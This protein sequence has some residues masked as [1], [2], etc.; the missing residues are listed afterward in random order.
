MSRTINERPRKIR[1]HPAGVGGWRH[2][3]AGSTRADTA[4]RS[5]A[6]V[7]PAEGRLCAGAKNAAG[8]TAITVLIPPRLPALSVEPAVRRIDRAAPRRAKRDYA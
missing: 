4:P 6:F 2:S 5:R 1:E 8:C 7:A 3:Y